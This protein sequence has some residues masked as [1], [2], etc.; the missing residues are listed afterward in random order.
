MTF[1][2]EMLTIAGL[3]IATLL[4]LS[5]ALATASDA[6]APGTPVVVSAY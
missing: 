2:F 3:G 5:T 4:V 6:R 1:R